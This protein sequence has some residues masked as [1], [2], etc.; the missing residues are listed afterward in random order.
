MSDP[1]SCLDDS[2]MDAD[3]VPNSSDSSDSETSVICEKVTWQPPKSHACMSDQ[4]VVNEN[5]ICTSNMTIVNEAPITQTFESKD[6]NVSITVL[7][8]NSSSGSRVYDKRYYCPYCRKPQAKLPRHLLTVHATENEVIK[9]RDETNRQNKDKLICKLRNLGNYLH[10]SLV[11]KEGQGNLFV[12]YRPNSSASWEDYVPCDMCL[13]YYVKWDLWKHRKRCP[14]LPEGKTAQGRVITHC[15]LLLPVCTSSSVGLK[16]VLS[17]LSSD[18][19]S[20]ILKSDPLILKVGEKVYKKLGHDQEQFAVIRNTMRE[21]GRLLQRL[22]T[23]SELTNA[24][25]AEFIDPAKFQ[26]V[27]AASKDVAGFCE[28]THMFK[29]PSLGLK[30]GHSLKKCAKIQRGVALQNGDEFLL[31]KSSRFLQLCDESWTEEISTHAL[32]TL[33]DQKRKKVKLIPLTSDCKKLIEYTKD[34]ANDAYNALETSNSCIEAWSDLCEAALVQI[35]LF[36]RRRQGEVSRMKMED[37]DCARCG[38]HE[39]V[40]HGLTDIEK[41]LCKSLSRIEIVG[42]RG[43]VVPVILTAEMKKWIDLLSKCRQNVG[44]NLNNKYIFARAMYGSLNH[45]RGSDCLRAYSE[46]CGAV[47]PKLLR[48]TKLRKQIATLSQILNLKDNEMDLLADFLGHDIRVHREFYR[49]PEHTLQV[50]KVSKILLALESGDFSKQ[51]G[52]SLSEI[53]VT[54]DEGKSLEFLLNNKRTAW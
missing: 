42:K 8:T 32:R 22:R 6:P 36:N 37:L 33:G 49:L 21:L 53:D 7:Q 38:E 46:A 16:K 12:T 4:Q 51:S 19:V 30:L 3:Y 48:S 35:I 50:A 9:Y 43:R 39:D 5:P 1:E 52:K 31:T 17:T 41:K 34:K 23:K 2:D 47:Q 18:P 24:G 27:V 11:I 54:A 14:L 26:L 44:V 10:N 28:E 13:G 45:V 29:T 15:Q 40:Q 25:L 20:R